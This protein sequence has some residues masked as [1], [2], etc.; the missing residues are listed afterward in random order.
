MKMTMNTI[1]FVIVMLHWHFDCVL[2]TFCGEDEIPY[3]LTISAEGT[4]QLGCANNICLRHEENSEDQKTRKKAV[5]AII[6]G[7]L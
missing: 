5:R 4:L 3:R 6:E 1:K 2:P 7:E